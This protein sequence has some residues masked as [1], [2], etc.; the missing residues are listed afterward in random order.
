[1]FVDMSSLAILVQ[2]AEAGG[3][4]EKNLHERREEAFFRDGHTLGACYK[5]I[6]LDSTFLTHQNPF[7]INNFI[8]MLKP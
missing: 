8:F 3:R 6:L 5:H 7:R 4:N 2:Q 1:S